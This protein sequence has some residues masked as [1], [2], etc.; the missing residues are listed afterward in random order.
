[1]SGLLFPRLN[2]FQFSSKKI[3][4]ANFLHSIRSAGLDRAFGAAPDH[5]SRDLDQQQA[6]H[7]GMAF[8]PDDDVVM[9]CDVQPLGRDDDLLGHLDIGAR[10]RWVARRMV[11][12]NLSKDREGL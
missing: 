11:C 5:V 4:Q 3:V 7:A 12:I 2:D 8:P 6:L 1:M 9:H 10:W